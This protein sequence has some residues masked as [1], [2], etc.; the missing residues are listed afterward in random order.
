MIKLLCRLY[1]YSNYLLINEF[2]VCFKSLNHTPF[3]LQS[4]YSGV[5][6]SPVAPVCGR[7]LTESIQRQDSPANACN[8]LPVGRPSHQSVTEMTPMPYSVSVTTDASNTPSFCSPLQD[9]NSVEGRITGKICPY[10]SPISPQ[11]SVHNPG[12]SI[13]DSTLGRFPTP[14]SLL[15]SDRFAHPREQ[16]LAQNLNPNW[17]DMGSLPLTSSVPMPSPAFQ[18]PLQHLP[19]SVHK[20]SKFAHLFFLRVV[21]VG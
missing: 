3:F 1:I 19:T 6:S 16:L 9:I 20:V 7:S 13:V 12:S 8:A 10:L 18:S 15:T 21:Q 11:Y 17:K 5:L 4:Q 2:N 14:Q